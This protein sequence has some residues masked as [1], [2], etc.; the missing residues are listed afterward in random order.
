VGAPYMDQL[1][2]K[3]NVEKIIAASQKLDEQPVPSAERL[4]HDGER[5]TRQKAARKAG[6]A[7]SLKKHKAAVANGMKGGRPKKSS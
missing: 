6:S 4:L 1:G 3:P 7:K 2:R 5:L